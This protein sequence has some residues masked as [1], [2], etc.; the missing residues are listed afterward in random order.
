VRRVSDSLKY[1]NKNPKHDQDNS[2]ERQSLHFVLDHLRLAAGRH[3]TIQ[4]MAS[5]SSRN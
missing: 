3:N 5:L 4:R 1:K 2:N